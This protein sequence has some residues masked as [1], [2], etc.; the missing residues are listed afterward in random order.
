MTIVGFEILSER[1]DFW[2]LCHHYLPRAGCEHK[3]S[4][5]SWHVAVCLVPPD[6]DIAS[7]LGSDILAGVG[8]NRDEVKE[9]C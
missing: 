7:T 1:S 2:P 9:F 8:P 4:P 6:Y 3:D 5:A